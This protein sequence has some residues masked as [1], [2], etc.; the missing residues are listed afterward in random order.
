MRRAGFAL[1]VACLLFATTAGFPAWLAVAVLL[2]G[3]LVHVTGE[4]LAAAGAWSLGFGLAPEDAQGQYQGL[5]A[6]STQLGQTVTPV[7]VAV[8]LT[9]LGGSGWIVFAA[10]FAVTGLTAPGIVRLAQRTGHPAGPAG[11]GVLDTDAP[12]PTQSTR[13]SRQ[14]GN[15]RGLQPVLLRQRQPGAC[16]GPVR[17]TA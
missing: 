11:A 2:V 5:F 16:L 8:L 15:D 4:M 6:M 3:G 14:G 12:D 17:H 7:V 1:A 10:L 13:L 9:Q